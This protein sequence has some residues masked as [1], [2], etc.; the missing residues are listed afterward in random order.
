MGVTSILDTAKQ[1][2]LAQQAALHIVGQNVAN[3]NTPGYTRERAVMVS[4]EPSSFIGALRGGVSV[5]RIERL[6]DQF[7]TA[8]RNV[9][10]ANFQSAREQADQLGRAEILVNDLGL[11][12]NS[13]SDNLERFFQA[14][15][16][17]ASNPQGIPER[18]EVQQQGSHIVAAFHDL[19]TGF[20]DLKRDLNNAL[21]DEL[22][23]INSL[24][25]DIANLNVQIQSTE[26]N[27][28]N[29]AASLRDQ[30]DESLRQL[31]EKVAVTAFDSNGDF[32]VLL[33][34]GRPLIEGE[35]FNRLISI[36][37][38]D[39][40]QNVLV[41]M[42]DPQGNVS[43]VS[44]AIIGGKIRGLL[45]VKDTLLPGFVASLDR[46]A[47]QLTTSVNQLHSNGY[48]LDGSTGNNFFAARQASGQ[49]ASGNT[50]GGTLQSVAVF[51]PTQ[52]TLDDYELQFAANGPPPTFDIVNTTTGSTIATA[53][54]YTSGASIRFAGLEVVVTDGSSTPQAGDIFSISSTKNAAQSIAVDPVTQKTPEKIAAAATPEA[55]D[56]TN[57]LSLAALR[58]AQ[59]ISGNTFGE[60]YSA[61]VS[62]VGT[63]KQSSA[64]LAEQR[65]LV[66]TEIE[67]RRE[68]VSG[69]SLDEEQIDLIRFQQAFAA[70]ANFIRVADEMADIIVN[71]VR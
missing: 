18:T 28:K 23:E 8:Q 11:E 24:A 31:S 6:F 15:Q 48:G 36:D 64:S 37:D 41:R 42:Q 70:A 49:S 32:T 13:F 57:A 14:F 59:V 1:A 17:L 47:A 5:D 45:N 2:L 61:L 20:Q 65:E 9:A 58:D 33:G 46:L 22:S 53:Q 43:D 16:D 55:G 40:P 56:N 60:A 68:A 63:E 21:K 29:P 51:D 38:P 66:V 12:E 71:L 44:N 62:S 7:I 69:V 34:S 26:A 35:R 67:N 54:P 27:P 25:R 3:V 4:T 50:G 39:D 10:T 52:M 30:R 19:H